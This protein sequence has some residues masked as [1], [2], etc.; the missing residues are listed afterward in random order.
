MS[1]QVTIYTTPTCGY[2]NM[3]KTF[4]AEHGVEYQEKNV[5]TDEAARNEMLEKTQQ[6]GVPVI[7]VNGNLMVGFNQGK[8]A[9]LLGISA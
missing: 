9:E 6:M 5:A 3:A 7:D 8:L 1:N 2:C 4:F